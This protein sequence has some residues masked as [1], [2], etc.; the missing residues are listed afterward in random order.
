M[1][2]FNKYNKFPAIYNASTWRQSKCPSTEEWIKM[3]TM[4]Y[5]SARKKE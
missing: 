4:E 3:W 2:I 1:P 5:Y